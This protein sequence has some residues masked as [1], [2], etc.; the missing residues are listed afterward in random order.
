M[1]PQKPMFYY[2]NRMG[3]IILLSLEE[4]IGRNGVNAALNLASL[5]DWIHN[6]PPHDLDRHVPFH[7]ISALLHALEGMYGPRAGR[8]V[9]LRA[10]RVSFKYG[11]R[12]FGS[13]M[14]VTDLTFRLLPLQT[15]IRLGCEAFAEVFNRF[16][17][18]RVRLEEHGEEILW[19]IERCPLCWDRKAEEPI[20]HM[21]VGLLQESLYWVS[22]GKIFHVEET[23]CIACG[24][25]ACTIVIDPT[26][27]T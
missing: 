6:Y 15:K 2:P 7:T 18:Q 22:G 8:G 5:S 12:A 1:T 10:G 9:A 4:I 26:P 11:L 3:R 13:E 20:C 27:L 25:S 24:D 16:T 19:H 23:H 17:D 21:A 14:G